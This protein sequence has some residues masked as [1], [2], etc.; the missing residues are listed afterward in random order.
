[1]QTVPSVGGEI[2]KLKEKVKVA[3]RIV[4][5]EETV[6]LG[7]SMDAQPDSLALAETVLAVP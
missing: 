2:T 6:E 1:M 3:E 7:E 4:G 5:G